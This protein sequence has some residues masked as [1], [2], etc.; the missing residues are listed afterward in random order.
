MLV[1]NGGK[2]S[3]IN[4]RRL[5]KAM[6]Q[7][8]RLQAMAVLRCLSFHGKRPPRGLKLRCCIHKYVRKSPLLHAPKLWSHYNLYFLPQKVKRIQISFLRHYLNKTNRKQSVTT[9]TP[10]IHRA[11]LRPVPTA[12]W[13]CSV[14]CTAL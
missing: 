12:K 14:L 7:L 2:M 6:L 11:R 13:F 5:N 3:C 9:H 8:V 4:V 10:G 1:E